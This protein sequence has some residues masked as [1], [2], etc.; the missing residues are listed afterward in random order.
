MVYVITHIMIYIT[1]IT[2]KVLYFIDQIIYSS[3]TILKRYKRSYLYLFNTHIFYKD[4]YSKQFSIG[5]FQG[6]MMFITVCM[7][8][9]RVF[10]NLTD[11]VLFMLLS[12]LLF[13]LLNVHLEVPGMAKILMLVYG[14]LK[15]GQLFTSYCHFPIAILWKQDM[16]LKICFK[17]KS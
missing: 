13:F 1:Y 8:I 7:C 12:T 6:Y 5:I 2:I 16:L 15:T 9:Y 4:R 17:N 14:C 10:K 3:C 11:S